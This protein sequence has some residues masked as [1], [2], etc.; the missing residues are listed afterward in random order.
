MAEED[1]QVGT[2]LAVVEEQQKVVG[3][4]LVAAS[5][6]AVLAENTDSSTQILEQIRDIQ[7]KTLRGISEIAKGIKDIF[8]LDK[9]QDRRAREDTTELAK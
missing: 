4:A 7:V 2:A 1:K 6:S 8:D 9:L 3:N 5:G